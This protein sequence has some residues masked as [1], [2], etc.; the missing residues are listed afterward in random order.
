MRLRLLLPI[1]GLAMVAVLAYA[2]S[3]TAR[4]AKVAAA[5]STRARAARAVSENT[6]RHPAM[7]RFVNA[8]PN[9]AALE[10]GQDSLLLFSNVVFGAVSPYKAVPAEAFHFTLRRAATAGYDASSAASLHSGE[11]YTVLAVPDTGDG[12]AVRVIR[13]DLV[14]DSGLARVR[15]IDATPG[16]TNMVFAIVGQDE[17]LFNAAHDSGG[18]HFRDVSPT[19]AGFRVRGG[20]NGQML[21]SLKSMALAAGTTYTFVLTARPRHPVTAIS[22]ADVSPEAA[23]ASPVARR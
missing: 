11:R 10:L 23:V 20:P 14:P 7:V 22:F 21:V 19:T 16:I 12:M 8:M 17:P 15:L 18:I 13:D 4:Q 2:C 9:S 5:D 3:T 1:V 6:R